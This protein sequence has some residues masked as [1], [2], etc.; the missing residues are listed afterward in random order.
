VSSAPPPWQ[1]WSAL[2]VVYVVWGSTYLAIALVVRDLPPLLSASVRFLVAAGL[3]AAYLL[4]RR[5]RGAL[6]APGSAWL[7]A[8]VVGVLLLLG[9]NGLVT[10]AEQ[11]S[12]P[13]GLAAL[14]V[15]G[16]PFWVVLLR[17][18]SGDRPTARVLLGVLVGFAGV[19]VLL[20]PGARPQGVSGVAVALVLSS[21]LLWS[22]GSFVAARGGLPADPLLA[23]TAEMTAGAV[24]L[25]VAGLLHGER[26][27]PSA[28]GAV[29]W[30]GLAYLV[31]AG[32]LAAFSAYSWLLG[33][34]P[35][36]QVA[37]YAYVN[38]VVAVGLGALVLGEHVGLVALLG[39]LVTV[40]GVAVVVSTEGRRPAAQRT[41]ELPAQT[42]LERQGRLRRS[43]T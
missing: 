30:G 2:G 13:S 17:A 18:L 41:E 23:T 19:A 42:P 11:R 32:S 7:R 14:L 16:V 15:A 12:L 26:L 4:V 37:T 33:V 10:L 29:S 43:R 39:G 36:S 28:V 40:L 21:S 35:T 31:V 34:A 22:L 6:R 38:P 1:V 9:G 27:H 5:G 8:S 24:A 25:G 3:L 20:L